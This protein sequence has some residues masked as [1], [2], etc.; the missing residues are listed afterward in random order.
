MILFAINKA[1]E[2]SYK[3][4]CN[5]AIWNYTIGVMTVTH[6]SFLSPNLGQN[7]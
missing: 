5:W 2:I 1:Q 4:D 6:Y 3:A 7:M